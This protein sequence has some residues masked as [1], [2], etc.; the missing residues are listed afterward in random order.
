MTFLLSPLRLSLLSAVASAALLSA[1]TAGAPQPGQFTDQAYVDAQNPN[2]APNGAPPAHPQPLAAYTNFAAGSAEKAAPVQ[3]GQP[4]L[5]ASRWLKTH[6]TTPSTFRHDKVKPGIYKQDGTLWM[7]RGAVITDTRG[8]DSCTMQDSNPTEAMRRIDYLVDVQH[9]TFIRLMLMSF[10]SPTQF[11]YYADR[12]SWES[13]LFDDSYMQ[14]TKQIIDYI[15]TKPNVYVLLTLWRDQSFGDHLM[16]T[17]DSATAPGTQCD[18]LQAQHVATTSCVWRKLATVF[19]DYPY[20]MYGL[21]DEYGGNYEGSVDGPLWNVYNALTQVVRNVEAEQKSPSHIVAVQATRKWARS[22]EYYANTDSH[23]KVISWHPILAGRG[24]N[25]VYEAH[26]YGDTTQYR[27]W[28]YKANRFLPVIIGEMGPAFADSYNPATDPMTDQQLAS[29][30]ALIHHC[31]GAHLPYLAWALA[32]RCGSMS[33]TQEDN[34]HL[35]DGLAPQSF[36]LLPWGTWYFEHMG[37]A[38]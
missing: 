9:V 28:F 18:A 8:C 38:N 10:S 23:G 33:M 21:T 26:P 13:V 1:C 17:L 11:G 31:E 29:T 20:V 14:A 24:E 27:G 2:F 5:D 25:V 6:M 36:S 15:G 12:K 30:K 32:S 34:N 16:P 37:H 4:N 7:G 22:L 35:C 3:V 19:K